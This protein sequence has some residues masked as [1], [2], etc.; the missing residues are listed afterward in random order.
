MEVNSERSLQNCVE[1]VEPNSI[2]DEVGIQSG[3]RL[4][5]I[6]G[7]AVNDIIEYRFLI[8]GES[9]LVLIEKVN[10]EQWEIEVEKEYDDDLGILFHNQLLGCAHHCK[11]KCLFCFVDQNPKGMRKTLY[12]KDDDSRLSF[13]QGNFVTLTNIEEEE[14]ERIIRYRISPINVSVH[15]T[16]PELRVKML[17]NPKAG[18]LL[19]LMKRF[20]DAGIEMSCQI[21]LIPGLN[22]G[23][24]LDRTVRE[25]AE[26]HPAVHSIAI[27]PIGLTKHRDGLAELHGFKES[28]AA[29]FLDQ[30][31]ERQ[32][33]C[34]DRLGTRFVFAG[35][36]FYLVARRDFPRA[37]HY[38][39]FDMLEDGVGMVSKFV[40][41]FMEASEEFQPSSAGDRQEYV[42]VTGTIMEEIMGKLALILMEKK[43]N[44]SIEVVAVENQ[45]YGSS[46]T[47]SGLLT[48]QD[49]FAQVSQKV[50][51]KTLLLPANVL[52]SDEAVFLDDMSLEDLKARLNTDIIIM[53]N[54]GNQFFRYF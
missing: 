8:A 50:K 33:E 19:P 25:L 1:F 49:I 35:D 28:E 32:K 2:A 7:V 53:E 26:L 24:H 6:N 5:S 17:K 4:I 10:G 21:V 29:A 54:D 47:V 45:F 43:L 39:D 30:L 23:A 52:K 16:D 51:G 12:F 11:N 14:I 13:L 42:L 3:D 37:D 38:E 34:L 27:V 41:E 18:N 40:H 15:T 22:D 44:I 31:I 46:I 36:E 48:A 9:I 20:A